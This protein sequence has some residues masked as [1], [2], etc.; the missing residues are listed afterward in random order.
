MGVVR[1]LEEVYVMFYGNG[2]VGEA[3]RGRGGMD[4]SRGTKILASIAKSSL[5]SIE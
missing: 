4:G 2:C 5:F 3:T 1:V